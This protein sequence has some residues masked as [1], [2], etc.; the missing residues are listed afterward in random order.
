MVEWRRMPQKDVNR[1]DTRALY[2]SLFATQQKVRPMEGNAKRSLP[3]NT[4]F[5]IPPE[6]TFAT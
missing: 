2:V 5:F 3:N 1:W 4:T 6:M